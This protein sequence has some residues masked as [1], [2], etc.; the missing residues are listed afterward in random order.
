MNKEKAEIVSKIIEELTPLKWHLNAYQKAE[1]TDLDAEAESTLRI[2][3]NNGDH[4]IHIP[5]E[6]IPP[7]IKMAKEH[8]E[9]KRAALEKELEE[10]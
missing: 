4:H 2:F 8:V 6:L 3:S 10:L 7:I 1:G 9:K 5:L